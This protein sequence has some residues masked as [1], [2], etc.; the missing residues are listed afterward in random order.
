MLK[1]LTFALRDLRFDIVEELPY[2]VD[3]KKS[4]FR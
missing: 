1:V 3:R 4:R 2:S